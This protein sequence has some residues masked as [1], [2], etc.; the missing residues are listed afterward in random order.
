[1][2]RRWG[3]A[4]RTIHSGCRQVIEEHFGLKPVLDGLEDSQ[5]TSSSQGSSHITLNSLAMFRAIR[6]SPVF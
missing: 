3:A 6:P 2:M 4:V 1:M 5:V